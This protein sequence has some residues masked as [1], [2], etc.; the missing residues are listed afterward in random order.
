MYSNS[1][2]NGNGNGNVK[3]ASSAVTSSSSATHELPTTDLSH[4]PQWAPYTRT[5]QDTMMITMG[6]TSKVS[7]HSRR[8]GLAE[9]RRVLCDSFGIAPVRMDGG[10]GG[11]GA[12]ARL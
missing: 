11:G 7:S 10:G 8:R 3:S 1:N 5:T 12:A 9:A 4:F 6:S 2:G